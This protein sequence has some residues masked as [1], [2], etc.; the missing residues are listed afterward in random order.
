M[1]KEGLSPSSGLDLA[2]EGKVDEA[3]L[4]ALEG[5]QLF[6]AEEELTQ[7]GLQSYYDVLMILLQYPDVIRD[8][9]TSKKMH[10]KDAFWEAVRFCRDPAVCQETQ[11]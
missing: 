11:E 9:I 10:G 7:E 3:A 2:L 6:D 8:T 4:S 5:S 1:E